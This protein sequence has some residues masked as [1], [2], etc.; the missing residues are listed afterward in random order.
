M[1]DVAESMQASLKLAGDEKNIKNGEECD[2]KQECRPEKEASKKKVEL[3]TPKGTR[4]FLPWEMTIREKVFKTITDCFKKYGAMTIDTPVFELKVQSALIFEG[5]LSDESSG[6][7]NWQIRRRFQV[8]LR[9]ERSRWRAV[10]PSL[11]FDGTVCS[12]SRDEW[13][14]AHEAISDC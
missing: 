12:S 8:D 6:S 14:T 13:H 1:Q 11:R 10:L 4:D 3:K 9:P 5:L 2:L 7:F